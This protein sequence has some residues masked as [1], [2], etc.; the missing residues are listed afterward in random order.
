[1]AERKWSNDLNIRWLGNIGISRNSEIK[2]VARFIAT[3]SKLVQLH[4][5]KEETGFVISAY[6]QKTWTQH[7]YKKV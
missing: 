3:G 7:A 2:I 5:Y 6:L 4:T 1:M